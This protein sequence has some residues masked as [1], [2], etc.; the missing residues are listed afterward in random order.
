MTKKL[1]LFV[2]NRINLQS[3]LIISRY[4]DVED[5]VNEWYADLLL[6]SDDEVK[7]YRNYLTNL[8]ALLEVRFEDYEKCATLLKIRNKIK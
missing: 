8:I 5:L 3:T 6:N 7:A 1:S 4:P 2:F